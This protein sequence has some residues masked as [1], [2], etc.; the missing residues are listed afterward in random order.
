MPPTVLAELERL[1][2]A[3]HGAQAKFVDMREQTQS[4]QNTIVRLKREHA[5]EAKARKLLDKSLG[6]ANRQNAELKKQLVRRPH[7]PP[8]LSARSAHSCGCGRRL[9]RG[10]RRPAA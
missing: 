10:N 3:N 9:R 6:A 2:H 4:M 1:Q 5:M 7:F 8:P